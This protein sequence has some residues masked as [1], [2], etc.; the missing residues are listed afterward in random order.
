MPVFVSFA[1]RCFPLA[2]IGGAAVAA[3]AQLASAPDLGWMDE[4]SA[5]SWVLAVLGVGSFAL[6]GGLKQAGAPIQGAPERLLLGWSGALV[7]AAVS[8][9]TELA[10]AAEAAAFVSLL[11]AAVLMVPRLAADETWRAVARP[12]EWLALA[13]GFGLLALTYVALP[14]EQVL[15]GLVERLLLGAEV[16]LVAVLA[17]WLVRLT[18]P[19]SVS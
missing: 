1:K 16:A 6:V 11:V 13:A 4:Y 18:R 3:L 10:L 7:L 17:G 9:V 19:L 15:I 12:V 14:G 2:A 8:P 5:A